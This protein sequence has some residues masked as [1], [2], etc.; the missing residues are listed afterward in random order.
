LITHVFVA[1][2]IKTAEAAKVIENIQRDINIALMN[3]LSLIFHKMGLNT[4]DVLAA[5]GTKWNF[6]EY[7][8]GLVGGHCIPVDPYYLVYKARELGYHPQVILAGRAV[9]DYKENVPDTRESPAREMVKAL[10][11][12]KVDVYGYD[13]LLSNKEIEG[14][15]VKAREELDGMKPDAVIL[16]VAHEQFRVLGEGDLARTIKDCPVVVDVKGVLKDSN[17]CTL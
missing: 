12:Y 7:T 9:N 13:P 4:K 17:N 1:R 14:F 11:E 2:D 16:A 6:H 8:P 3:E 5:A 10:Q 15:G